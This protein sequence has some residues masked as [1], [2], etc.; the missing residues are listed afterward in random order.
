M[1]FAALVLSL[2]ATVAAVGSWSAARRSAAEAAKSRKAAED[3]ARAQEGA[4]E[5]ARSHYM[6]ERGRDERERAE[7][8]KERLPRFA[9]N[10][11]RQTGAFNQQ[12]RTGL[13]NAHLLNEGGSLAHVE[14]A[15]LSTSRGEHAGLMQTLTSTSQTQ[16]PELSADVPVEGRL[17]ILFGSRSQVP[18][19]SGSEDVALTVGFRPQDG[20]ADEFWV[21]VFQL[22]R[23]D[24][25]GGRTQWKAS[26]IAPPVPRS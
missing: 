5:T 1:E 4:T 22:V 7:R 18:D 16:S 23:R 26:A 14:S 8:A 19:L 3:S 20:N 25:Q 21:Q 13:F 11:E 6:L 9:P 12:P 15:I 24:D 17:W 2:I 10:L